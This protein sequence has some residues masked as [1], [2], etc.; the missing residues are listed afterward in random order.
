MSIVGR[1]YVTVRAV[2]KQVEGDIQKGVDK[3][4]DNVEKKSSSSSSSS[5]GSSI[6]KTLGKNI[7]D[8]VEKS[9]IDKRIHDSTKKYD[10]DR[11]GR[12]IGTVLG[13]SIGDALLERGRIEQA[14]RK[15]FDS[16]DVDR[17]SKRSGEKIGKNVLKGVTKV[18]ANPVTWIGALALPAISDAISA[19]SA[20]SASATALVGTIG[21][22]AAAAGVVGAQ[23]M[24]TLMQTIGSVTLAFK[25]QS[26]E[27]AALKAEMMPL[28][29]EWRSI[30]ISIQRELF[31]ALSGASASLMQN[32]GPT[33]KAGLTETGDAVG[34][35]ARRLQKLGENEQFQRR[36]GEVLHNNA[37]ALRNFGASGVIAASGMTTIMAAS[38]PLMDRF[39]RWTRMLAINTTEQLANAEQTGKL[40]EW[41]DRAGDT[42]AQWG[43]ILGDVS[44]AL[45]NTFSVGMDEGNNLLDMLEDVTDGWSDWTETLSGQN[46]MKEWFESAT[47]VMT[48]FGNVLEG[49]V[50][51]LGNWAGGNEQAAKT[52][53]AIADALPGIGTVLG[54]LTTA[55]RNL[56]EAVLPSV[57]ELGD[58][59]PVVEDVSAELGDNLARALEDVVPVLVDLAEAA[60]RVVGELGPVLPIAGQVAATVGKVLTPALEGVAAVLD[61]LPDSVVGVLG[62]LALLRMAFKTTSNSAKFEGMHTAFANMRTQMK[63]TQGA[64]SK[65]KAG[66]SG[67]M[68]MLGG[69]WGVALGV[70]TVALGTFAQKHAESEARVDEL[71]QSFNEQTGAI[72]EN[73]TTIVANNLEKSG[74]LEAARALGISLDDVTRAAMG[75]ADAVA[76]VRSQITEHSTAATGAFA[77]ND[78]WSTKIKD[79]VGAL[80]DEEVAVNTLR[81]GLKQANGEFDQ[82]V[83]AQGRLREATGKSVGPTAK[84]AGAAEKMAAMDR[85]VGRAARD[86]AR[87]IDGQKKATEGLEDATLSFNDTALKMIRGQI[88]LEQAIDDAVKE[89]NEGTKTLDL[90]KEAGRKNM[91]SLLGVAE[92]AG[93]VEGSAERQQRA[94]DRARAFIEKYA[95]KAGYG[96]E[97]A[98]NFADR[99][100]KTAEAA[101]KADNKD[102]DIPVNVN[103]IDAAINGLDSVIDKLN[104]VDGRTFRTQLAIAY[105]RSGHNPLGGVQEH[106]HGGYTGNAP[107]DRVVG[108]VHGRE[109]VSDAGTTARYR[110][111]LEAM[112]RGED[113]SRL[114]GGGGTMN[115]TINNPVPERAGKSLGSTLR[116]E[117]VNSGWSI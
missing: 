71:T 33:L 101:D 15:V 59:V 91:E 96:A 92:A 105:S 86:A 97:R 78:A 53:D 79:V 57:E 75:E 63:Q 12:D 64:S 24:T 84:L 117:A 32:L 26:S 115:V 80:S 48:S 6:G 106:Q 49:L 52:L 62:S 3:A 83:D 23:G 88:G 1:A 65:F 73:T 42:A 13:Q 68:G 37:D 14:L 67:A 38:G 102:V 98:Q 36:L 18:A 77:A 17:T 34:D 114:G 74:A 2:T 22:A 109:W 11:D 10:A 82:A 110:G 43:R 58:L 25:T 21:P 103:G 69:P 108:V 5:S 66:M 45:K 56:L 29:D 28:K 87:K 72:T 90:N 61:A 99:L 89:I 31:P 54:G 9:D 8:G 104:S 30:G 93:K 116:D 113:I 4:L 55:A 60:L 39:S 111:L 7:G 47:P 40:E 46:A 81:N 44:N 20:A 112:S 50:E 107:A 94:L 85:E 19:V 35:V 27:L 95:D 76:R 100:I 16:P 51:G 41:F 70:A